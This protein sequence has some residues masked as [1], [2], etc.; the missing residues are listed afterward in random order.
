[1]HDVLHAFLDNINLDRGLLRTLLDLVVRPRVLIETYFYRDR[2]RY[3]KP[4]T[5]LM[6]MLAGAILSCRHCLP[7]SDSYSPNFILRIAATN[8]EELRTLT[9]IREYDDV[10]RLLFVPATAVLSYLLFRKQGWNFAEHLVFNAY[11]L[12]FQFFLTAVL[13]P[14]CGLQW[15]WMAAVVS[16]TFFVVTYQKCLDGPRFMTLVKSCVALV[17]SAFTFLA[18]F[19]P[20]TLWLL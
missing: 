18:V 2:N 1:M 4:L 6:L 8:E 9:L 15:E 19:Y 3:T 14:F 12:A 5:L 10:F 13:V 20:F 11:I 7:V 17:G 16:V